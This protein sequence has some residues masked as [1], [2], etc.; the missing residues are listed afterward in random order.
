MADNVTLNSGSGGVTAVAAQVTFSGDTAFAQGVFLGILSGSADAY[1]YNLSVGGAGAVTA[2]T[3]RMTLASDDPAVVALQIIDDWD[4][5]DRCKV[6]PIVGSAGVAGGSGVVGATTQRVVLATDVALPTGS[7]VIGGVTQ[8]GTWNVVCTNAG[9]FAVQ[10]VCTNA[11]TFVVQE[12]GA[13]L[14]A[15]QLIDDGIATVASAITTKGMAAVG[16]DGTNARIIKTD[17]SGELQVDVLT[18]PT[19]T[20]TGT[21]AATQSGTW[22]VV[23][24]NAG[25][26]AVQE[27]G[28]ALTKLTDIETN[29]DSGAVIGNGAAATA[30]RVT[31]ANDSTG[32]LAGVTTVTTLTGGG[33]AHDSVDSGNPNKIGARAAATLSDDTMVANADR[34]DAV[35][36]LDG[37]IITRNGFPLGDLITERAS[38]TGGTSTA[39]ANFGA[40][41]STRNY[42]TCICVYNSSATAGYVDIRDGAAGSVLFT[43]PL[44]AGG[45]AIIGNGSTPILYSTANTAL[46]YDVSAA[47]TTVYISVTGFKS[48]ARA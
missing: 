30:Q 6:N 35:S 14:T 31:I 25:T 33:V 46:A 26:F 27:S 38:D 2:G 23:C 17:T 40:T 7:N 28:T 9:T 11:G 24:T 48:K 45:G 19:T 42:L 1:T 16:T 20:V 22:N 4:E 32:I 13:A 15:L 39:F 8:S 47:L 3:P 12:N 37:A 36:D 18:M 10:A 41:A 5:S 44:P 29:T 21:I 34:T 43:I